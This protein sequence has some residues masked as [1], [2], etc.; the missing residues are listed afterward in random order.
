[1]P[2]PAGNAQRER[3]GGV[4]F[5]GRHRTARPGVRVE[6]GTADRDRKCQDPELRV[7]AEAGERAEALLTW[8]IDTYK[9]DGDE[10]LQPNE[11][12]FASGK[13]VIKQ[14]VWY[15]NYI[16]RILDF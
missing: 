7:F 11:F 14:T 3:R 16:V 13:K 5:R 12:T 6:T 10:S 8:L 9:R 1:M 4:R 15:R 2:E